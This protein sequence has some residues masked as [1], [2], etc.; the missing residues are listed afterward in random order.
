MIL[1]WVTRQHG[2]ARLP[3]FD[4]N[5]YSSAGNVNGTMLERMVIERGIV[6]WS[7]ASEAA[8]YILLT[9]FSELVI[10]VF[11]K[12]SIIISSSDMISLNDLPGQVFCF[13]TYL[14]KVLLPGASDQR[15]PHREHESPGDRS[16]GSVTTEKVNLLLMFEDTYY[17]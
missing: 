9:I 6:M 5:G 8:W 14:V 2:Y 4:Y 1:E 3:R 15:W 7:A 11:Q 12:K 17:G 13:T 10:S 16:N